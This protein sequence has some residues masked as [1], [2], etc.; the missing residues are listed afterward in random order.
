[1]SGDSSDWALL[2]ATGVTGRLILD[3]ATARGLR[4]LLIGR[5]RAALEELAGPRRLETAVADASDAPAL[6]AALK[7]RRLVLNAAGPFVR[8]CGPTI[9][10]SLAVGCDYLDLNGEIDPLAALLARGV[11]ARSRGVALV[12]GVGFG[13]AAADCLAAQLAARLGGA[14]RLRLS[15]DPA[16]AYA[17]AAVADSTLAVLEL[18]GREVVGGVLTSRPIGRTTWRETLPD[19]ASKSFASA[20]LAEIVAA[21]RSLGVPD[22]VA[23]A[24]MARAQAFALRVISPVLPHLLRIAPVRRAMANTGGHSGNGDAQEPRRSRVWAKAWKGAR[25][26]TARIEAGEGFATAADIAIAAIERALARR[27]EPGAHTP[28]TAFGAGFLQGVGGIESVWPRE[29]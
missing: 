5:N 10:A 8:T 27:P 4:P 24:P 2:G 13:V 17:T 29:P 25:S 20:P 3:R 28:S 15:I 21:E 6:A 18:G 9:S 23:G 1:M 14:D 26:M 19:G 22:I 12:G 11:E 16:S 7:G